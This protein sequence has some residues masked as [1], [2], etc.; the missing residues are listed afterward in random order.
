LRALG[1]HGVSSSGSE[2]CRPSGFIRTSWSSFP[3]P[4]RSAMTACGGCSR[5]TGPL[6]PCRSGGWRARRDSRPRWTS[7]ARRLLPALWHDRAPHEAENATA[8]GQGRAGS[9]LRA[10]ERPQGV[11]VPQ[12]RRSEPASPGVGES[13]SRY[14]D[15]RDH[16]EAGAGLLQ[17]S[18][19]GSP[20]TMHE[21]LRSILRL[22]RLSGLMASLDVVSASATA[23]TASDSV[24]VAMSP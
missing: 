6:L 10:G 5:S 3:P 23:R 13:H 9:R 4:L 12:P 17:R 2:G 22:L 20:P 15:S 18:G 14:Q 21:H 11:D 24:V 1:S 19:T 7:A 8:Q 16:K